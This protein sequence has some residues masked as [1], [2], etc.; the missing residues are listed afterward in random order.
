LVLSPSGGREAEYE[1]QVNDGRRQA[2]DF[3]ADKVARLPQRI[4]EYDG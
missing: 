1:Q 3:H 4:G 2:A